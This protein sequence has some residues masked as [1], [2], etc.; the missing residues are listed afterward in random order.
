MLQIKMSTNGTG[1]CCRKAAMKLSHA[2][3]QTEPR[4]HNVQLIDEYIG[5]RITVF[6]APFLE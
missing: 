1:L 6:P 3:P 2:L 4:I 5:V